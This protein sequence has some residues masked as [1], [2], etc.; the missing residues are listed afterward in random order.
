M[1]FKHLTL[2]S[3]A[4]LG[5]LLALAAPVPAQMNHDEMRAEPSQ[6]TNE[7]QRIEQPLWSRAAVTAT[8]LSLVGLELWWFLLSKPKSR[9]AST[10]GGIQEIT[11]TVDGG[12]EPSQIVVQAGQPVRL[13][14]DRKDPSSCLEEVR[15]PDFRIARTLPVNQVTPIEFTPDK[16]G[17]Y[18]FTCGMNMFRGTV[19]VVT[20]EAEAIAPTALATP[21]PAHHHPTAQQAASSSLLPPAAEVTVTPEGVQTATVTVAKGYQPNRVTVEAGQPVRLNFY[22]ENPSGCYAQLLIPEFGIEVELPQ[23]QTT[24]VEFTP[25]QPGEYEFMCGMKMNFGTIEV[26]P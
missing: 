12:Y 2:S 17:H 15:F 21:A 9:R 20:A 5:M 22:R 18:E 10:T 8:G 26:R 16:P 19:E 1:K 6:Q 4:S 7:F 24:A 3:L 13:D 11:V 23:G 25:T 14:F